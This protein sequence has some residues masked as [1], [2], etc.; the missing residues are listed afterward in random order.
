MGESSDSDSNFSS[1]MEVEA[2]SEISL[3]R[4]M[5]CPHC[6]QT[7]EDERG[8]GMEEDDAVSEYSDTDKESM[9]DS[10]QSEDMNDDEEMDN[11]IVNSAPTSV[12]KSINTPT[13][14]C[15]IL[16][17][18]T[19]A[20]NKVYVYADGRVRCSGEDV[21]G[22]EVGKFNLKFTHGTRDYEFPPGKGIGGL[23]RA[24]FS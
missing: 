13:Y 2:P 20:P 9:D 21:N 16:K 23:L 17:K 4:D 1:Y 22:N 7:D 19:R 8:Y 15:R 12:F 5:W 11:E 14:P 10:E 6:Y 18:G 3:C 24:R